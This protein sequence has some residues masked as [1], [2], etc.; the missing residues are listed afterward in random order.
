MDLSTSQD[1]IRPEGKAPKLL[2][3]C[4]ELAEVLCSA[5][6][7]I[8]VLFVFVARFA[9]VVGSSMV[10]TLKNNDWLCITAF[11]SNPKRGEIVI[12]SPRTISF[13]EPLVK[14]VIAVAGDTVDIQEGK[15]L[16]NGNTVKETYLPEGTTT[17][18]AP[19][20][21]SN[22]DYPV[23]VPRGKVFVM[24]DNRGGSI[25][26]RYADV[27]FIRVNDLL[28]KV[29]LRVWPKFKLSFQVK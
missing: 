13:H 16:V 29:L 27:G 2:T 9:G 19:E 1:T 3:S 4:F 21:L 26:S 17:E 11:L 23:T 15:V 8:T 10:P 22:I 20:Y 5:V 18:P 6:L 12:I 7:A 25:D 24:G 14:R 28:G